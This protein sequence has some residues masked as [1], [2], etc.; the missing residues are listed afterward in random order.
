MH[1]ILKTVVKRTI[2]QV[3]GHGHGNEHKEKND[4]RSEEL[5][6]VPLRA[7]DVFAEVGTGFKARDKW[8]AGVD[9]DCEDEVDKN[10]ILHQ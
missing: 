2:N 4:V 1:H 9:E 8:T 10:G 5:I 3:T 7:V 6:L